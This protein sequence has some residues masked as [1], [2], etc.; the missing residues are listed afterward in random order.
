[1]T[2]NPEFGVKV[3]SNET[4][5]EHHNDFEDVIQTLIDNQPET[6]LAILER[7][8]AHKEENRKARAANHLIPFPGWEGA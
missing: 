4:G 3:P 7:L 2:F 6:A 5:I 8:I 1:M